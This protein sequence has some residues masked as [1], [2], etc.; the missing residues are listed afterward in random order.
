MLQ[1]DPAPRLAWHTKTVACTSALVLLATCCL[2]AELRPCCLWPGN[3]C[4]WACAILAA[5]CLHERLW[6]SLCA[7]PEQVSYTTCK[8]G[9]WLSPHRQTFVRETTGAPAGVTSVHDMGQFPLNEEAS[10]S[11]LQNVYLHAADTGA[12]PLRVQAMVPLRSW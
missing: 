11:T 5:C 9:T 2:H 6:L 3:C 4:N 1:E 10:Y 12:L 7:S 8:A